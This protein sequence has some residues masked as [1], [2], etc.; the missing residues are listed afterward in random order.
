M[1]KPRGTRDLWGEE[2]NRVREAQKKLKDMFKRYG[3]GEIE[4]P[5]FEKLDL[6]TQKS[7]SEIMDQ[8]YYFEDK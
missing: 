4:T 5:I 8:I 2:L 1:K 6:F 3:Y 7:G